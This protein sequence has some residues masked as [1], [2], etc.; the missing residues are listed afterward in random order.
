MADK[1]TRREFMGKAAAGLAGLGIPYLVPGRALGAEDKVAANER[2]TIGQI[3]V[4]G[5]GNAHTGALLG[6]PRVEIAAVADVYEP[7][8]LS[9]QKRIGGNCA[10]YSDF[11]KL[12][13]RK[14]IDA[15]VI[16]TP[17]HWHALATIYACEAGKDVYC[18]KPFSLT[19]ED[20]RAMVRAVQRNG[21][22][23][24]VGS[25]Q[26]SDDNFRLACELVRSGKIGK[27]KMTRVGIGGGPSC[28]YEPNVD[29][30]PTLDWDM[31]L[32]PA[33]WVPYTPKRCI[34]NFRWFY[35]YSGGM[36]TD[37]GHHHNDIAQWGMGTELTGPVYIEGKATFPTS[38]LYDTA[39]NFDVTYRYADGNVLNTSNRNRHGITFT[40]TDGWVYVDRGIIEADPP[41][42]LTEE[43]GP[44]DVHLYRSPGHHD[45][46]LDC[47]KTR[48][49]T[50]CHE[51]IGF[52]SVSVCH[53]GNIAMRLGRPLH[54]DPVNERFIGDEEAN[55]WLSRP[56][57]A[58]WH[59]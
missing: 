59:L 51:E 32:G 13:E 31:W 8:R 55:R 27:L 20:G 30:P 18:E 22:I 36:M 54:W 9:T 5:M 19:I 16:A 33:P 45:N 37:W 39:T 14:D 17:D 1:V 3:G 7:H 38:G 48:K 15:V 10:A 43:L 6:N 25:Q 12:L 52:R 11:R 40:G 34:Y 29:P 26:R 57:R 58:P 28:D 24:Q 4:G 2:I 46:W 56:Y 42:L 47:I 35:D 41:E 21:R 50:I 23:F 44:A 53:L 49:K